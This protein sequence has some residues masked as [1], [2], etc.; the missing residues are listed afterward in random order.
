MRRMDLPGSPRNDKAAAGCGGGASSSEVAAAGSTGV[1]AVGE[2]GGNEAPR[3]S[4]ASEGL[5]IEG[6]AAGAE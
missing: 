5:L 6:V 1:S 3:L 4:A 2:T